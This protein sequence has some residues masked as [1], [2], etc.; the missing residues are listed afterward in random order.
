M[1]MRARMGEALVASAWRSAVAL[2]DLHGQQVSCTARCRAPDGMV[3][4]LAVAFVDGVV[5]DDL[6][7]EIIVNHAAVGLRPSEA[8][9]RFK[10]RAVSMAQVR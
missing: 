2:W 3:L 5:C 6:Y 4:S 7:D 10:Q 1:R 9:K 8:P